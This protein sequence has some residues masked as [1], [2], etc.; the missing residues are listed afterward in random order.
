VRIVVAV[1][2]DYTD[3]HRGLAHDLRFE[4]GIGEWPGHGAKRAKDVRG[5]EI[6]FVREDAKIAKEDGEIYG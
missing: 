6:D 3:F 5:W 4:I 1:I 2:Y